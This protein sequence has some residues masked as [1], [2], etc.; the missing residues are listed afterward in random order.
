MDET[1]ARE[2]NW[3][4]WKKRI[5]AGEAAPKVLPCEHE[6]LS[7]VPSTMRKGRQCTSIT[8]HCGDRGSW[9]WRLTGQPAKPVVELQVQ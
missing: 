3:Q 1:K 9:T 5:P 8:V 2:G 4:N 7:T 6:D